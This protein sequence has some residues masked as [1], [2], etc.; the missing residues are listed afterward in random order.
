MAKKFVKSLLFSTGLT[1]GGTATGAFGY[2]LAAKD[3]D[4]YYQKEFQTLSDEAKDQRQETQDNA[5]YYDSHLEELETENNKLKQQLHELREI[6]LKN[7]NYSED[8]ARLKAEKE[9]LKQELEQL[10]KLKRE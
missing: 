2:V 7:K 9:K 10:K 1:A 3:K 5:K 6:K 8:N 4:R